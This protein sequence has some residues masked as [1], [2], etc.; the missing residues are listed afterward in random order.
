[1]GR[2]QR[3]LEDEGVFSKGLRRGLSV[4]QVEVSVLSLKELLHVFIYVNFA[5]VNKNLT[6]WP[7]GLRRWSKVG[8]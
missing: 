5:H 8:I 7:S 4:V 3:I 1:M 2:E 6:R